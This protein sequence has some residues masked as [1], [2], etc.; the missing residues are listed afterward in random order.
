MGQGLDVDDVV[1]SPGAQGRQK[2]LRDFGGP[3]RKAANRSSPMCV[4]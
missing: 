2:I 4:I 1:V 3:E